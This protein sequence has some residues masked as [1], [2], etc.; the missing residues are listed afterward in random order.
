[1]CPPV[2]FRA[3]PFSVPPRPSLLE[4]NQLIVNL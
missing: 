1:M 4:R 3:S 2:D